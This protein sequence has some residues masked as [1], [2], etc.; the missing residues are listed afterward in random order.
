MWRSAPNMTHLIQNVTE[1]SIRETFTTL[2]YDVCKKIVRSIE[3]Y[4]QGCLCIYSALHDDRDAC[5]VNK[6]CFWHS[7][8]DNEIG[9]WPCKNN[10]SPWLLNFLYIKSY[11]HK[12]AQAIRER[13]ADV[14]SEFLFRYGPDLLLCCG[15]HSRGPNYGL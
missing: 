6:Q 9:F 3:T 1:L 2:S 5:L 12:V 10:A 11:V 15:R 14:S 4:F 8:P 13:L 7:E